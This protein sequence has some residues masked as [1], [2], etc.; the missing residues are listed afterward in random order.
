MHRIFAS[1]LCVAFM[2]LPA[3]WCEERVT[4]LEDFDSNVKLSRRWTAAGEISVRR[5]DVPDEED[6][7]GVNG[8]LVRLQGLAKSQFAVR[9]DFPHPAWTTADL[10]RF[11]IRTPEALPG[12]PV[13]LE[14]HAFSKDRPATIWRKFASETDQWQTVEL[15]LHLFRWSRGASVDWS[16]VSR[17]GFSLRDPATVLIDGI[18]LVAN[19]D[20]APWITPEQCASIAFGE[21]A[22]FFRGE[23]FIVVTNEPRTDGKQALAEFERLYELVYRDFPD[24]PR[25]E[26]PLPVL[27]FATKKQFIDFWPRLAGRYA[28]VVP[29]VRSNGYSLLGI[30]ASYYS[31]EFG[32]V[33]PVLV[34]EACHALLGPATGLSNSSE[35]LH[36]GLANYYQLNWTQQ[37]PFALN[38]RPIMEG[39]HTPLRELTNGR[40][41]GM[42]R[43]AQA[44]LFV[45]W[46]LEDQQRRK[47]FAEAMQTMRKRCS[48]DLAP[49]CEQ[50]FGKSIDDLELE[51]LRWARAGVMGEEVRPS[52]PA[53]RE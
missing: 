41:I 17:F 13:T 7:P 29:P 42:K 40:R 47:Q 53:E 32:P 20:G 18:E 31:E 19:D 1:A 2:A 28:S 50:H 51:W 5:I 16:N 15:P 46:L 12:I 49:V 38:R 21:D 33:R 24:L 27:V 43:Y 9:P 14:F 36:E 39:R 26:R 22:T 34:H 30:P 3:A 25:P 4:V 8:K 44:T 23:L 10:I 45:K 6:S 48:T 11:R 52:E 35:W 37:D